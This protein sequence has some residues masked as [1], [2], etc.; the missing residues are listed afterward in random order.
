MTFLEGAGEREGEGKQIKSETNGVLV[1]E[2]QGA[3]ENGSKPILN[4][5]IC[6]GTVFQNDFRAEQ[7]MQTEKTS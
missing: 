6:V 7:S 3:C 2:F 4:R 1:E 5:S